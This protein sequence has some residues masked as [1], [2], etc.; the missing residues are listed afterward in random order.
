MHAAVVALSELYKA[1]LADRLTGMFGV[2]WEARDV[3][4]DRNPAWEIAGV[5]EALVAEFSSRSRHIDAETDRLIDRL[6]RRA[7]SAAVGGDDHEALRAQ[8]TLA[9]RPEKQVHSLADL[10]DLPG[11]A[12]RPS[13][14]VR[15]RPAG[16]A[17]S[18]RHGGA[19]CCCGP[20]MCRWM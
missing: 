12:R 2:E 7:R 9:T 14:S 10:T 20:M 18:P 15:M 16:R 5:P 11:G 17:L 3:G 4:R 19:R 8:A 13:C 6:H 1:V